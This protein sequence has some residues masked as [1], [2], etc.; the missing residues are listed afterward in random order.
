M[1][2]CLLIILKWRLSINLSVNPELVTT[3]CVFS[4]IQTISPSQHPP[5]MCLPKTSFCPNDIS[6]IHKFKS[7]L[8]HFSHSIPHF[9]TGTS[10]PV[11]QRSASLLGND[12]SAP[13]VVTVNPTME[14]ISWSLL[15]PSVVYLSARFKTAHSD[16]IIPF[17]KLSNSPSLKLDKYSNA[18]PWPVFQYKS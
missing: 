5:T 14:V 2:P 7:L 6:S 8:F 4:S 15:F 16:Y 9:P 1:C 18:W 3:W 11:P 12:I 13:L 10:T 17:H